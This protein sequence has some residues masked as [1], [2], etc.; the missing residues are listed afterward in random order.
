M[1]PETGPETFL[2]AQIAVSPEVRGQRRWKSAVFFTI[3]AR[4]KRELKPSSKQFNDRSSG[5]DSLKTLKK[6]SF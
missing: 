3:V 4:A 1:S 6:T 5:K 2:D